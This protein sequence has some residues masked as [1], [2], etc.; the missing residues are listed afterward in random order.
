[1]KVKR[2]LRRKNRTPA[3]KTRQKPFSPN[4]ENNIFWNS[5]TPEQ[6]KIKKEVALKAEAFYKKLLQF[7]SRYKGSADL[8]FDC[9]TLALGWHDIAGV[10]QQS[11][12]ATRHNCTEANISRLVLKIKNTWESLPVCSA[13]KYTSIFQQSPA[14]TTK[15]SKLRY[16]ELNSWH[17]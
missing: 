6:I 17:V 16:V 15:A 12:I 1:L 8:A 14:I 10:K 7:L 3:P 5:G 9:A 2:T 4:P 11:E 13:Q